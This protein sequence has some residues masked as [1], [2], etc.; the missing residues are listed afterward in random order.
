[1]FFSNIKKISRL[2]SNSHIKTMKSPQS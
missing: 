2:Y 1:M